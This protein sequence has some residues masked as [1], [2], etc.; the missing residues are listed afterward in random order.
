VRQRA[1]SRA[2]LIPGLT[3]T[4]HRIAMLVARGDGNNQIAAALALRPKTVEWHLTNV[5]RK[6]GIRT[7]THLAI[8]VL[9]R[10]GGRP[11]PDEGPPE[12]P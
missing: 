6:L 8:A 5:Y 10:T 7:R 11:A 2:T 12:K 4:E 1:M 3:A 9:A